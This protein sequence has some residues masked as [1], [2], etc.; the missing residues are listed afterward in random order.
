[1]VKIMT[2]EEIKVYVRQDDDDPFLV[3]LIDISQDYIDSM[4]GVTYKENT[5]LVN[6]ASL[7]QKKLILDM[8][9]NRGTEIPGTTKTDK[10]VTSILDKLGNYESTVTT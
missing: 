8:Y 10:I 3:E 7:L 6:L 4:V 2:L 1:M 9:G 5:K